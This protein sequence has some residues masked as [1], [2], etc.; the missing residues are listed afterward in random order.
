VSLATALLA[1]LSERDLE[2]LA[3]RLRP[4]LTPSDTGQG[5]E[6]DGWLDT[7]EAA[8]YAGCSRVVIQ[9]AALSGELESSQPHGAAGK[10]WFTRSMIDRWRYGG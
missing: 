3:K 4:F 9:H 7:A 1:E 8:A 5:P 6:A 10:R 2:E